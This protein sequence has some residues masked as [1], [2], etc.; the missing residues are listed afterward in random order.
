MKIA[1]GA[2]HR[3]YQYKKHVKALLERLGH[4]VQDM[5]THTEDSCDYPDF[6]IKVAQAVADR[7]L[8]LA[9]KYISESEIEPILKAFLETDFEGGRHNQR[10]A[11]ITAAEEES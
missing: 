9:G 5:G 2:D 10:L 4:T 3:G 7:V 6:G 1:I 8:V 11:K